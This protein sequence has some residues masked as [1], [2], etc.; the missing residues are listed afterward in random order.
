LAEFIVAL[1]R[2]R[3]IDKG[4]NRVG[5]LLNQRYWYHNYKSG[6][7]IS[8]FHLSTFYRRTR[9]SSWPYLGLW[10]QQLPCWWLI[11]LLLLAW[12]AHVPN[13]WQRNF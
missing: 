13:F 2:L 1:I 6:E 7:L 4:L 3:G 8:T 10:R 12:R 9:N 5:W 11:F